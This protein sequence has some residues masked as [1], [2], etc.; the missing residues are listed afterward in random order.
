MEVSREKLYQ[1]VW[2]TPISQLAP[3]EYGVSDVALQKVCKKLHVPTPPRGYWAKRQ[4]GQD[5]PKEPL[6]DL[7]ADAPSTHV[8]HSRGTRKSNDRRQEKASGTEEEGLSIPPIDIPDVEV[9]T[10]LSDPHPLVKETRDTLEDARVDNY[11]RV[12]LN[13]RGSPGVSVNV[14]PDALPRVLRI[15]DSLVK[16][17]ESIG[18][19]ACAS[20]EGNNASCLKVEG[21]EISFRITEKTNWEETGIPESERTFRDRKYTYTPTGR[22]YLTFPFV[23][24]TPEGRKKWK[25]SEE[26]SL[27]E[28]IPSVL[29]RAHEAAYQLKRKRKERRREQQIRKEKRRK[30]EAKKE[31][32]EKE[33]RRRK[34]LEAEASQW[35]KSQKLRH[36]IQAVKRKVE[37]RSLAGEEREEIEDWLDWARAHAVRLDPISDELPT[38]PSGPGPSTIS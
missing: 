26:R 15:L 17:A 29:E 7:P 5:P 35:Q 2:E 23:H 9:P 19:E 32:Q 33:K 27:E 3:E 14:S 22:L 24:P 18:W 13:S 6:P 11:S 30:R 25:E 28:M 34:E 38:G 21:E 37:A 8:F 31:R 20:N 36:Y 12:G 1:K 10:E 16:A 4:H